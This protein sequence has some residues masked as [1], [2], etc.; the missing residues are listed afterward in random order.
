[1]CALAIAGE[2]IDLTA[3][4]DEGFEGEL[5]AALDQAEELARRA[6]ETED[7]AAQATEV[8]ATA[9][10][11]LW[12][13]ARQGAHDELDQLRKEADEAR[14]AATDAA[15]KAA[16]ARAIADAAEQAIPEQY[17]VAKP[18]STDNVR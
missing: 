18:E 3:E 17:R 5:A 15:R 2:E 13:C 16:K 12:E 7:I 4:P 1:M 11:R 10:Q 6:K 9:L 8:S 14:A